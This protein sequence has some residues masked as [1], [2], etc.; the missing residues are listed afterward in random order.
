MSEA[1]ATSCGMATAAVE[2]MSEGGQSPRHQRLV[3]ESGPSPTGHSS[4]AVN[5]IA[6]AAGNN[7]ITTC[8]TTVA[9]AT[10][11]TKKMVDR[12]KTCPMYLRLFCRING[13]HRY[14]VLF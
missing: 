1:V 10:L 7:T 4:R 12:Q 2:S 9:T 14:F 13:H 6:T 3:A 5:T 11:N 8:A